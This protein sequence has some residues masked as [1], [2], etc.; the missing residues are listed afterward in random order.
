[1]GCFEAR[2]NSVGG[3]GAEIDR[4]ISHMGLDQITSREIAIGRFE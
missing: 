3:T 4:S 1:M 2:E